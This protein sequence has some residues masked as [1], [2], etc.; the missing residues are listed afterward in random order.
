LGS[1]MGDSVANRGTRREATGKYKEGL[2]EV[3]QAWL[4]QWKTCRGCS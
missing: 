3:A 1:F 2:V 4:K